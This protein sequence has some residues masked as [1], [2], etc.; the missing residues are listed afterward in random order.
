MAESS[1][2]MPLLKSMKWRK[3]CRRVDGERRHGIGGMADGGGSGV[4]ERHP[5]IISKESGDIA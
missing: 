4:N 3:F 5:C 2:N 1:C